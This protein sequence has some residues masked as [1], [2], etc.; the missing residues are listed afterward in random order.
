[1]L[2]FLSWFS[3]LFFLFFNTDLEA[4]GVREEE[5]EKL[6]SLCILYRTAKDY[7]AKVLIRE[8]G[9][10][11]PIPNVPEQKDETPEEAEATASDNRIPKKDSKKN[12][13]GKGISWSSAPDRVRVIPRKDKPL[14]FAEKRSPAYQNRVIRHMNS[15][16]L[17]EQRRIAETNV[18]SRGKIS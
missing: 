17:E 5:L 18:L 11:R 1:M 12:V 15:L 13:S 3:F 14:T 9:R 2:D 16:A 4:L 8:I 10:P 6:H 7:R